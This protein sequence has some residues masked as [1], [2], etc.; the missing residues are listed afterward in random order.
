MEHATSSS[1]GKVTGKSSYQTIYY[2]HP[3]A[4]HTPVEYT[5]PSNLYQAISQDLARRLPLKNLH[6]NSSSRPLRSIKSLHIELLP[7]DKRSSQSGALSG[8]NVL[9]Q[10][11]GSGQTSI[12]QSRPGS[13]P[14][15]ISANSP[16]KE[17]RHQIPGLRQTPYLKIYLLQCDSVD[18]YKASSRKLL[19]EWV[20]D[21]T[22]PSQKSSKYNTQENHDAFE[23]L[24]LH[25]V[26]PADILNSRRGS[27]DSKDS[28]WSKR[29]SSNLIEK[30][31]TDF[32]GTSK[33]AVDRVAQVYLSGE[34]TGQ[35]S[36][37]GDT[38]WGDLIF[39]LKS[40]ILASFDLRVRQYEEDIKERESQ[41]SLPGWNFN[42]FFVLKEGLAKG[43]ES[44]GLIEDA[45]TSYHELAA[46]LQS[47][48]DARHT[49]NSSV[50]DTARFQDYTDDLLTEVTEILDVDT[51]AEDLS[52][53]DR[54]HDSIREQN[55]QPGKEFGDNILQ[56]DRK[57]FREL[58]LAN[59]IS[60]F[61]FQCYIFA[62]QASLL[63][64][65]GNRVTPAS[66][67]A[68]KNPESQST[69]VDPFSAGL[70]REPENLLILAD[71]CQRAV[72]FITSAC[73]T[74]RNELRAILNKSIDG[75][76]QIAVVPPR[77]QEI[78]VEDLTASWTYSAAECVLS[79]T[80]TQSLST[81]LQP[82]IRQLNP[83]QGGKREANGHFSNPELPRRT[84]S[85]SPATSVLQR[86]PSPEK[87]PSLTSL[88]ALRL[89]PPHSLQS[90]AQDL[91]ADRAALYSLQ[92][93][94]LSTLGLS[95]GGWKSG[96]PNMHLDAAQD[97][98]PLEEVSLDDVPSQGHT[99]N[100]SVDEEQMLPSMKGVRNNMLRAALSSEESFYAAYET[101]TAK[102]LALY[103]L[104]ERKK[105]AEALTADLAAVRFYL[106]DYPTAAAYFRQLAPFYAQGQWSEVELVMLDLYAR[107]LEN[108]D[109][110][111]EYVNIVLKIVAK[112]VEAVR[113]RHNASRDIRLEEP[114][115][116]ARGSSTY[117]ESL[118]AASK[119]LGE[120]VVAP[121][122]RYIED[123][124]LDP[125]I[126]HH[127][128][129]DTFFM[130]LKI[131]QRM[132]E[133][134][135][136]DE[137][138]VRLVGTGDEQG[139]EIYL[140]ANSTVL[141]ARD[142]CKISVAS[143]VRPQIAVVTLLT[144]SADYASWHL[145]PRQGISSLG[146]HNSPACLLGTGVDYLLNCLQGR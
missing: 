105:S 11:D 61:D 43:F 49:E 113:R 15:P 146:E 56:T 135:S 58:I 111:E 73:R 38:G 70:S 25:V 40:L 87:Y 145:Q 136:V 131:K 54:Q 72:E 140:T 1:S 112:Q 42:T 60:V 69:E 121:M 104:G 108:L 64:R 81:Q 53:G 134:F 44:V 39:K 80:S 92:R 33:S 67:A 122:E 76:N 83:R 96:W 65:L 90:G 106:Q 125:Q 29:S 98:T 16:K 55:S 97:G 132:Q 144:N 137:V 57:P 127:D 141:A 107:C 26:S 48:L 13:R 35:S 118:I 101:I 47:I 68:G 88:D 74:M 6:W 14:A 8:G 31:R 24:I 34:T 30:I 2:W 82:L 130:I 119:H 133:K 17:R 79:R 52:N 5:D 3:G 86:P 63:L 10:D 46:G 37:D 94:A 115:S 28:R 7:D 22:P 89:L 19:R 93:R 95:K 50:T 117:L 139:T 4:N 75:E 27:A 23:W 123:V 143:K 41:R 36:E 77:M 100:G 51:P 66:E 102:T 32:N 62:R 84:S 124:S 71:V 116:K 78:I 9:A 109:R 21:H 110:K 120:P 18:T 126:Q 99:P 85:L 91:A 129:E 45:L 103:V 59:Q 12:E 138:R 142:V 114:L 20:K 128:S